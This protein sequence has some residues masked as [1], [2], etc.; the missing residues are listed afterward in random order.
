MQETGVQLLG[1]EDLL[2]EGTA[3]HSGIFVWRI[4][5]TEE[6]SRLQSK[7]SQRVRYNLATRQQ[8]QQSFQTDHFLGNG[9]DFQMAVQSSKG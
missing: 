2:E 9:T 1:Q 4:P 5:P 7:G 6:L 8:Q 3:P